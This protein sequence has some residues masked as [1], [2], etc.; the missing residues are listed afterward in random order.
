MKKKRVLTVILIT[1][2]LIFIIVGSVKFSGKAMLESNVYT[3]EYPKSLYRTLNYIDIFRLINYRIE[4]YFKSLTWVIQI[5]LIVT[6]TSTLVMLLIAIKVGSYQHNR[7][8]LEKKEK[9]SNRILVPKINKIIQKRVNNMTL[10]E[11]E[12][13]LM[14]SPNFHISTF[15]EAAFFMTIFYNYLFTTRNNTNIFNAYQILRVIGFNDFIENKLLK[16]K[17]K[18]KSAAIQLAI[19][20]NLSLNV[21]YVS[22]IINTENISLRKQARMYYM[23]ENHEDSYK[24]LAHIAF[25]FSI[26]D[27]IELHQI[28]KLCKQDHKPLPVFSTAVRMEAKSVN[29]AFFIRE[30]SYWGQSVEVEAMKSYIINPDEKIQRAAI[31]C[32]TQRRVGSAI[33]LIKQAAFN[34]T[35]HTVRLCLRSLLIIHK[36]NQ[37]LFFKH[38][39]QHASGYRTRRVALIC[40]RLYDKESLKVYKELYLHANGVEKE[41]FEEVEEIIKQDE[42]YSNDL[43]SDNTIS[44]IKK[45]VTDTI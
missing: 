32:M 22:R 43:D 20:L 34:S 25:E 3:L 29:K 24:Y 28:I 38:F 5:S 15:E 39:Y 7:H 1:F 17:D 27:Q 26:W 2:T 40:L 12:K 23:L 4:T 21:S 19:L 44:I 33:N 11:V 30:I 8:K 42:L 45:Y 18:E 37:I 36:G 31:K 16:G 6:F 41:I 10:E 35:Q 13:T 9:E 14:I